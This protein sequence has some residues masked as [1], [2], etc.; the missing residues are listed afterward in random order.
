MKKVINNANSVS[1]KDVRL[2][3]FYG[4]QCLSPMRSKGFVKLE[5]LSNCYGLYAANNFTISN[6]YSAFMNE[7]PTNDLGIFL[8]FLI[9]GASVPWEVFEFDSLSELAQWLES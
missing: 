9:S 1:V 7:C 3:K 6:E 5:K 2:N 8:E 4:A